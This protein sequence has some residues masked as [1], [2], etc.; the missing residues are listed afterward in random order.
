MRTIILIL[1][2]LCFSSMTKANTYLNDRKLCKDVINNCQL[3][4]TFVN[5]NDYNIDKKEK[6]KHTEV[7]QNIEVYY[8]L[9]IKLEDEKLNKLS[10]DRKAIL[11]EKLWKDQLFILKA[12]SKNSVYQM[13]SDVKI[14]DE[15]EESTEGNTTIKAVKNYSIGYSNYFK[16]F[17]NKK[18][19]NQ[20][21]FRGDT[22][23]IEEQLR[24]FDW[25]IGSETVEISGYLCKTATS[26]NKNGM[27]TK[28]WFTE[29]IAISNGPSIY[30]GLPGL[31]LKIENPSLSIYAT[32]IKFPEKLIIQPL[33]EGKKISKTEMD[34]IV[35]ELKNRQD[36]DKTEGNRTERLRIIRSN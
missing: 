33:A 12:N 7:S 16:D 14:A 32:K 19:I 25:E 36:Y 1:I 2:V 23:L 29:D 24:N 17:E 15:V 21:I 31:I 34:K 27:I 11:K 5:T 28:A 6:E 18:L 26:T 35:E 13:A 4:N 22:Y 8:T 30:Q 9:S 20:R 3:K 10:D